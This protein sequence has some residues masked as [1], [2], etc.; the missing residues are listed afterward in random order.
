MAVWHAPEAF[1]LEQTP[2]VVLNRRV[3]HF[4]SLFRL[5][6]NHDAAIAMAFE[7]AER[8]FECQLAGERGEPLRAVEVATFVGGIAEIVSHLGFKKPDGIGL[9]RRH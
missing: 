5:Q 6:V 7:L 3:I 8:I 9:R 2:S 4:A 1:E